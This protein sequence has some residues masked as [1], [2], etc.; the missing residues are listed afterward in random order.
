MS[1]TAA[2]GAPAIGAY[3]LIERLRGPSLTERHRA[4]AADGRYVELHVVRLELARD[5]AFRSLFQLHAKKAQALTHPNV[6]RIV[7]SGEAG[8]RW[9]IAVEEVTGEDLAT[10]LGRA[11]GSGQRLARREVRAIVRDVAAGLAHAHDQGVVHGDLR[12][13]NVILSAS[14]AAVLTGFVV[15]RS[16][17]TD[18]RIAVGA[19]APA[20][21]APEQSEGKPPDQRS[22]I[23]ALGVLTYELLVG[24]PPYAAETPLAVMLAHGREPLP[25]PSHVEPAIGAPLERVLLRALAVDPAAR[26]ADAQ[27]FVASL[28]EA[29]EEDA[30]RPATALVPVP[31]EARAPVALL[32]SSSRRS[33]VIGAAGATLLVSGVVLGA[34]LRPVVPEPRPATALASPVTLA[35]PLATAPPTAQPTAAPTRIPPPPVTVPVERPPTPLPR[36]AVLYQAKLDGSRELDDVRV[37]A[38]GPGDAAIRTVRGA[39]ELEVLRPGGGA[40]AFF[41][42]Q[43]RSG[44]VGEFTVQVPAGSQ[45]L[46]S[47]A[48]R[49]D[50]DASYL[51]RLDAATETMSLVYDDGGRL[52]EALAPQVRTGTLRD[53]TV[54]IEFLVNGPDMLVRFNGQTVFQVRDARIKAATLPPDI[55]IGEEG[56]IGMFRITSARLYAAP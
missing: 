7:D 9:Y 6:A 37:F 32:T 20:Y 56:G 3:Q 14:G 4:L 53:R 2:R 36:A 50:G 30:R 45:A 34:A 17:R 27:S 25:L 35:T 24:R 52:R 51:L 1:R 47:W 28:E 42:I 49:R 48:L 31:A 33:L 13:G 40:E 8:G 46:L 54:G 55:F 5:F 19:F 43:T 38:G 10:R 15:A 16:L 29:F 21:M 23:Y 26:H 41:S 44:L 11:R 18:D 12:P 39:I 22:D